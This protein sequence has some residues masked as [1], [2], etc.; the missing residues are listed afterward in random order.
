[1]ITES[2]PV[3]GTETMNE[4]V[5]AF[6][7]PF[8]LSVAA[9]GSTLH[10]QSGSGAPSMV[11]QKIPLIPFCPRFLVISFIGINSC[12]IPENNNPIKINIELS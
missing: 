11:A 9:A 10:E 3:S 1:M 8:F 2:T 6:E 4:A 12:M 7:A 5:A